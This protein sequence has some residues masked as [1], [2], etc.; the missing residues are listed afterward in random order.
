MSNPPLK[1]H[2]CP[3]CGS[4]LLERPKSYRC[5]NCGAELDTS[6]DVK[7]QGDPEAEAAARAAKSAARAERAK[8]KNA[9]SKAKSN[10]KSNAKR[11]AAKRTTTRRARPTSTSGNDDAPAAAE[12]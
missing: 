6:F 3:E 12:G 10:G 4:L 5:W 8:A 7:K 1:D 9:K 2:P 11:S